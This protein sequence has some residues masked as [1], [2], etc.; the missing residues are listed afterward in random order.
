MAKIGLSFSRCV[1][2]IVEGTVDIKDVMVIIAR[3][4][5]N[6]TIETEWNNIWAGYSG[7]AYSH[8]DAEWYGMEHDTVKAVVLELYN[9]GL[10]HQPRKFGGYPQRRPEYWLETVLV[11]S[12]LETNPAV[13]KAWDTF[14]ML[15]GLTSITLDKDYT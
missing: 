5:F 11:D 13:K 8:S 15:A 6:P 10:L 12:D 2:D 14:Q 7:V 3:T 4:D 1:R 9:N